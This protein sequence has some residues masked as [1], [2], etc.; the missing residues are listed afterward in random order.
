MPKIALCLSGQFRTGPVV[1]DSIVQEI[2]KDGDVDTFI[3]TWSTVGIGRGNLADMSS[4]EVVDF[5]KYCEG[6]N[7]KRHMIWDAEERARSDAFANTVSGGG[8]S[9][10]SIEKNVVG[11][12]WNIKQAHAM[13][14]SY[15]Q[16]MG[17]KYDIIIRSRMDLRFLE[18]PFKVLPAE[19]PENTVYQPNYMQYGDPPMNDHFAIGR[20]G[21][22]DVY[23]SV[24]D[25]IAD[26]FAKH[27]HIHP[28]TM[29][30]NTLDNANL[31]VVV[32]NFKI[33]LVRLVEPKDLL[34]SRG[35][36]WPPGR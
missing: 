2:I 36:V 21:A 35:W 26:Y 19:I 16:E 24:Y 12:Y 13:M 17:I 11:M 4:S 25:G 34:P 32:A 10:F 33:E 23:A 7:V 14:A 20:R 8:G 18:S 29:L 5:D 31:N 6:L 28:E 1:K 30:R 15:E 22:M 9:F 27:K 3:S